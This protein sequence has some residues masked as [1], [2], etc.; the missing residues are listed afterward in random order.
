MDSGK[1]S[2][3]YAIQAWER[4]ESDALDQMGLNMEE[5]KEQVTMHQGVPKPPEVFLGFTV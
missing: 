1:Q 2:L 3:T 4:R 5:A